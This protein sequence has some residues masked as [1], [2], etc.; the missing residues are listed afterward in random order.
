MAERSGVE[1]KELR[2]DGGPTRNEFLMQFQ[3]DILGKAIVRSAIEEISALGSAFLAGL[4]V[5][6]WEDLQAIEKL[7]VVDRTFQNRMNPADIR[8]LYKGWKTAVDRARYKATN[9]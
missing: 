9:H 3:T 8:E 7:R 2:V 6:L 4:A 1:L 5:G